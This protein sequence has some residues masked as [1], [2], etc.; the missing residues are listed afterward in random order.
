MGE[1]YEGWEGSFLYGAE[2]TPG[3]PVVPATAFGYV[4]N[5]N[6]QS[7]AGLEEEGAVGTWKPVSLE[8]GILEVGGSCEILPIN[9]TALLLAKRNASTGKLGS[10]TFHATGGGAGVNHTGCKINQ[11]R[12]SVDA[13][14]R[15]R[16]NMDWFALGAVD[17]AAIAAVIPTDKDI[18]NWAE[19]AHSLSG[20]IAGMEFTINQNLQRRAV[21]SGTGTVLPVTGQSRAPYR[22]KEGRQSVRATL[23]FFERP[24][25]NVIADVLTEIA[26]MTLIAT[27]DVTADVLTFTFSN[28]KPARRE[29][30]FSESSESLW[31]LEIVFRDWDVAFTDTP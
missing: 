9:A 7:A 18:F 16:M 11:L 30:T 12:G 14:G 22:I 2:I 4:K 10:Y 1:I 28:G 24:S 21:I 3:T 6:V 15:L 8:E 20:E 13:G 27:G 5:V 29:N 31:P 25:Q 23:R 17:N 19:C 26:S